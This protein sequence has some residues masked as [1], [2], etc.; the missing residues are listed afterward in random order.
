MLYFVGIV[1]VAT[2]VILF[3]IYGVGMI[4]FLKSI[5][6]S[7]KV[8]EDHAL[9]SLSN[10]LIH[11]YERVVSRPDLSK[12]AVA[13]LATEGLCFIERVHEEFLPCEVRDWLGS[14]SHV[15][16]EILHEKSGFFPTN[17]QTYTIET[18]YKEINMLDAALKKHDPNLGLNID[19]GW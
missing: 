7:A 17:S 6:K 16:K 14:V 8:K 4:V 5:K 18:L 13:I 9:N 15:T 11:G 12:E 2:L 1:S 10:E 3:I 19:E